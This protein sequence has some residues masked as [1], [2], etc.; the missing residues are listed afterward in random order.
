MVTAEDPAI[1]PVRLEAADTLEARAIRPVPQEDT[2]AVRIPPADRVLPLAVRHTRAEDRIPMQDPVTLAV[3][4]TPETL[5][6]LWKQF[7]AH[8]HEIRHQ[9]C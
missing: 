5:I 4:A 6:W 7:S 3:R 8:E 9:L 1:P 2:P